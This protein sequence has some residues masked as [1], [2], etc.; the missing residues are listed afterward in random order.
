[1][2]SPPL[3]DGP[4]DTT[5]DTRTPPGVA[6]RPPDAPRNP[7]FLKKSENAYT[8][9]NAEYSVHMRPLLGKPS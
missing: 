2:R 5:R 9:Q 7:I 3:P 8:P 6:G 1:M 4:W